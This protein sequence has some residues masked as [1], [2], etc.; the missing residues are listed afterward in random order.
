MKIRFIL[1]FVVAFICSSCD[2]SDYTL[3]R[4]YKTE[5]LIEDVK[6]AGKSAP[7]RIRAAGILKHKGDKRALPPLLEIIMD[8]DEDAV[9]RSE[10]CIAAAVLAESDRKTTNELVLLCRTTDEPE[11]KKALLK[12]FSLAGSGAMEIILAELREQEL[13][14]VRRQSAPYTVLRDRFDRESGLWEEFYMDCNPGGGKY[15]FKDQGIEIEMC[16][17]GIFGLYN[18]REFNGNFDVVVRLDYGSGRSCGVVLFKNAGG[19]PDPGNFFG[20]EIFRDEASKTKVRVL[21][22]KDGSDF[23]RFNKRWRAKFEYELGDDVFGKEARAIRIARDEKA[24]CMHFYYLY[25]RVIDGKRR[26]GWMEFSTL[27]DISDENFILYLYASSTGV[28]HSKSVFKDVIV[29]QTLTDDLSDEDTGFGAGW[30]DYTFSGFTGKGVVVSF[31]EEFPFYKDSK[32]VFWSEANYQPWW[33]IDD[34]CGVSYE[35]CE[36]WNGGVDGCCEPMSD[37]LRR[38]SKADIVESNDARVVV[39]WHYVLANTEYKWWGMKP[40]KKPYADEWY[41]FYPD[42]TGVRKL[43]YTPVSGT[44]YEMSWNEISELMTIN[45]SGV[46]PSEF[47]SQTAVTM[48]NLEGKKIDFLWDLSQEKAPAKMDPDTR[49]WNEAICRINL[50]SRP[51]VF[52]VFAQSD[53]TY[54]KTFPRQYKDWWGHYGQDWSF[55]MRGGY[56]FKDDFWTFSHWPISKIPYDEAVKTNGKFLREPSHTSL[57]PVAGHPGATEVT[58]WAMLIGL[59]EDGNDKDLIDRTKSWLYPGKIEMR[60]GSSSFVENDYYQRALVFNNVRSDGKCDFS[61][62]PKS[63]DSIVINPVFIIKNWGGKAVF[64]K[65][66]GEQLEEGPDFRTAVVDGKAIVWVKMKFEEP[67]EFSISGDKNA[68]ENS[69]AEGK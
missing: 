26:E 47:L 45:R 7:E 5:K 57:L 21:S 38:W 53:E 18:K 35:F 10:A 3:S 49:S 40:D 19:L 59:G 55:E 28:K 64:V 8:K 11:I 30:R 4:F 17:S 61:L 68:S 14:D 12:A 1:V 48:L 34:K 24:K 27:P 16:S 31:G 69:D 20:V 44:K 50:I 65:A 67:V 2:F 37:R 29:E 60:S 13:Y 43:V 25:D 23:L 36:I 52:E 56:E 66:G 58:T 54:A 32:F 39:H 42:G 51:A 9:L 6:D 33:H 62:D 22:Q 46:R 15:Y 41:Y 63:R